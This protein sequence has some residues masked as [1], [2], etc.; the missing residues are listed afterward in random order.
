MTVSPKNTNNPTSTS[1]YCLRMA[2]LFVGVVPREN[3][4]RIQRKYNRR[5][6]APSEV[7]HG[8]VPRRKVYEISGLIPDGS[9]LTG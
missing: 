4:E 8:G 5:S 6:E 2:I 1:V 3:M 7:D 9:A